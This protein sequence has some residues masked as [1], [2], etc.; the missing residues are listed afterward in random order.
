MLP[1]L[2]FAVIGI[3]LLTGVIVVTGRA[4]ARMKAESRGSSSSRTGLEAPRL[5]ATAEMTSSGTAAITSTDYKL[6]NATM[7]KHGLYPHEVLILA[8]AS[9]YCTRGNS[10]Q[11]FWLY[12]YGVSDIDKQ[13]RSLLDRGFLEIGSLQSAIENENLT[14]LKDDLK[15]RGL[16]VS[17]TQSRAGAA[18]DG[19]DSPRGA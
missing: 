5:K 13:L 3:I 8:Y 7:S 18:P 15:N 11:S 16:K 9:S 6:K 4:A 12:K 1:A 14:N 2:L 17:G 10:F 19:N